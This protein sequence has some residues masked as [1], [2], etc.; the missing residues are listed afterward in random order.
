VIWIVLIGGLSGLALALL[1]REAQIHQRRRFQLDI[2]L[3]LAPQAR[4]F[5]GKL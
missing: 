4:G 1:S 5:E 2:G 3:R